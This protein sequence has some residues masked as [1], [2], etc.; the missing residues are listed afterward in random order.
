MATFPDD[1]A[2]AEWLAH[3]RW[4]DGFVCPACGGRKGWKLQAKPWTW[5]C[6]GCGRQ[7]STTAGTMMHRTRLL[8]RTWFA[9]R[10]AT[11]LDRA[12]VDKCKPCR[13]GRV[14]CSP[15]HFLYF[16][17]E[18]QGQGSLRPTL[19]AGIKGR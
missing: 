13:C 19:F 3:R 6:A 10:A 7:T 12:C 4:P 1:A 17:P 9:M 18:P 16:L 8:L 5:E 11:F 2:C 15:Q 14:Q